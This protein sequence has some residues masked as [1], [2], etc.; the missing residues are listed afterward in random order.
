MRHSGATTP[1]YRHPI[2]RG[3]TR[4]V[5]RGTICSIVHLLLT[6]TRQ[7]ILD[8]VLSVTQSIVKS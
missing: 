6:E 4:S 7:D 1:I 3:I 5:Q 8:Y 2:T